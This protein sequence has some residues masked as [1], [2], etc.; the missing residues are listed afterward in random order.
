MARHP[1]RI[2][3]QLLGRCLNSSHVSLSSFQQGMALISLLSSRIALTENSLRSAHLAQ[4]LSGGGQSIMSLPFHSVYISVSERSNHRADAGWFVSVQP[5]NPS[6]RN[7]VFAGIFQ[8]SSYEIV[9]EGLV[10]DAY[11]NGAAV[12]H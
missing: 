3:T 2:W 5:V 7:S 9:V 8:N 10:E 6:F 1:H 11:R 4:A 12:E